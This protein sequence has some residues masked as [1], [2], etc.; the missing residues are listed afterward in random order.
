VSPHVLWFQTCLPV[1]E[2]SG[3]AM[4]PVALGL[5]SGRGGLRCHHVSRSSKAASWCGR[6]L[7]SPCVPWYQTR[8]P[9]GEGSGVATSPAFQT[10]LLVREDSSAATCSMAPGRP[11]AGEGSGVSWLSVCYGPQAKGKY[12][13]GLLT[14][15]GPPASKAFL[16]VPKTPNIRLIMTSPGMQ[17]R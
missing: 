12:L 6:A 9:A 15:L 2:G 8:P 16:C 7:E 1:R 10:C 14:R 13:A 4:C 11:P 5:P 3:V 17:S